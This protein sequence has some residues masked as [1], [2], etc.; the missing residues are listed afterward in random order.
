MNERKKYSDDLVK[1]E[2]VEEEGEEEGGNFPEFW[3]KSIFESKYL[4][5]FPLVT[6]VTSVTIEGSKI[7]L[8]SALSLLSSDSSEDRKDDLLRLN[9]WLRDGQEEGEKEGE[10]WRVKIKLLK[11]EETL[12]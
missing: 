11:A 6:S 1:V 5:P 2:E 10:E 9:K 3:I 4:S 7:S 12:R 8:T